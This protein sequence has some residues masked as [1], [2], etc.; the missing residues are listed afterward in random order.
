MLATYSCKAIDGNIY[1]IQ[2]DTMESCDD[3]IG[4][5]EQVHDIEII[6]VI[7]EQPLDPNASIEDV[8]SEIAE[9]DSY[10]E[11]LDSPEEDDKVEEEEELDLVVVREVY[12][13]EVP[14]GRD[15]ECECF[16]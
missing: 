8:L 13:I 15:Q 3:I 5:C 6:D 12:I 11:S 7:D 2:G 16:D 10:L 14:T 1:T 4:R 9:K